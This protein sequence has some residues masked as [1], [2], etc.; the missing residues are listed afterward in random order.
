MLQNLNPAQQKAVLHKKGPLLVI[1]GAGS[2]KTRVITY[3][4]AKL[5]NEDSVNPYNILALTFTNKA[6]NEMKQRIESLLG[7]TSLDIWISTFH[8]ACVRILRK[9]ISHLDYSSDFVI[10]DTVDQSALIKLCIEEI[11]L[12]EEEY[13]PK[14]IVNKISRFKNNMQESQI[15]PSPHLQR[16]DRGDYDEIIQKIFPVYQKRLKANNALDFDDLLILTVKLFKSEPDLLAYYQQRFQYILVDEYQDTN[17]V[18]HQFVYLL[19]KEHQNICVV[20]DEDQSIYRWRGANINN[21]LNF[22]KNFKNTHVV[23]LE[24]NYRSTKVILEAANYVISKNRQR[25][26]KTLFTNNQVGEKITCYRASSEMDEGDF[27]SRTTLDFCRSGK[28]SF[29]DIAVFYRTNAQSRVIEDSLR[30]SGISYQII[31]GLKFYDRKEIKNT[32]AYCRFIINP[33]D[34]VSLD[35]IINTKN[36]GIGKVTLGKI[37]DLARENKLT[38]YQ[39]MIEIVK[40]EIFTGAIKKKVKKFC[41]LINRLREFANENSVSK[42]IEYIQVETGYIEKLMNEN[43]FE[44]RNRIENLKELI[45]AAENFE[46][47]NINAAVSNFLDQAA[48]VSDIDNFDEKQGAVAL[49]TLHNS[50]GL[51]FPVV[52]IIGM[53]ER[54]FPHIRSMMSEEEMEEER[55]LCYVGMTRAKHRLFLL[56]AIS[57]KIYGKEQTNAPSGFLDDIPNE[58]LEIVNAQTFQENYPSAPFLQQAQD[59]PLLNPTYSPFRKRGNRGLNRKFSIGKKVI[60]PSFGDGIILNIDGSDGDEILSV[61]FKGAGKKKLKSKYANLKVL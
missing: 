34:S 24:E 49:M 54:I 20:G 61:F 35:R 7:K 37:N 55:R 50:K 53:E 56:N 10:Y 17:Y 21:I 15:P 2:G 52:F 27:I 42:V 19:A 44:A 9:D 51:E 3:R 30:K 48:L 6:S 47:R 29:N 38:L 28:S 32:I 11:G 59:R 60:H 57:R 23:K 39:A 40:S 36:H 25:K 41:D 22:E 8:S 12:T 18:Q 33:D 31:G 43:T 46:E 4:I 5:I 14:A 58:F 45:T 16:G 13:S 26:E 1:A